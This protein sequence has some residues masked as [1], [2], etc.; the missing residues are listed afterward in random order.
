MPV[1]RAAARRAQL[2]VPRPHQDR[3]HHP[4]AR[5]RHRQARGRPAGLG[6]R[7]HRA[8]RAE[9]ARR[10]GPGGRDRA[11]GRAPPWLAPKPAA[12]RR[13]RT[14]AVTS[15]TSRSA[16]AARDARPDADRGPRRALRR[17]RRA[18]GGDEPARVPDLLPL[19]LS[20]GLGWRVPRRP[21]PCWRSWA[22]SGVP[23]SGCASA[24]P[25]AAGRGPRPSASMRE[26]GV[27]FEE[28]EILNQ[29]GEV[30]QSG[31]LTLL[32]ARRRAGRRDGDAP[33]RVLHPD[34]VV[35]LG[36]QPRG[37]DARG[38]VRAGGAPPPGWSTTSASSSTRSSTD[39]SRA[40]YY[41]DP[42]PDAPALGRPRTGWRTSSACPR[43]CWWASTAS[44]MRKLRRLLARG[45][46]RPRG[47]RPPH[48]GGRPVRAAGARR[49]EVPPHT[50][51]F[52]DFV[53][54]TQW[55]YRAWTATA[56]P[57]T[58]SRTT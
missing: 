55:I 42:P 11:H 10:G 54:H 6:D 36:P 23:P 22:S 20:S 40:L 47:V 13:A 28:R 16:R 38:R 39:A 17:A 2:E 32:V 29:R 25:S 35:R 53:A 30:V 8:S 57:P 5:P 58:R 24:T 9:P 26:G 46:A 45:A 50:T 19:C 27:V 49:L 43:R 33:R 4:R 31:R 15:R 18:S 7:H 52:T 44:A 51:V 34:R 48:A 12:R 56:S 3:R 21:S 14:G 37:R 41:C 1:S